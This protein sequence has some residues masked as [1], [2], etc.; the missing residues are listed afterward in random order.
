M[1][2]ICSSVTKTSRQRAAWHV[3]DMRA[4]EVCYWYHIFSL[5]AS[6]PQYTEGNQDDCKVAPRAHYAAENVELR[7]A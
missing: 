7:R 4:F 2:S 5:K 1:L 3:D 6:Y